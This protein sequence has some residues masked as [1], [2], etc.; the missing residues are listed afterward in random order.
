MNTAIER[1]DKRLTPICY[2]PCGDL[3]CYKDAHFLILGE[4]GIK[5]EVPIS[6][7]IKER[8]L[9]KN[10]IISRLLR[11]GVRAAVA[12]DDNTIIYLRNNILYELDINSNV[13]SKGY[14]CEQG[15]RPLNLVSVVGIRGFEDGIYFGGY[16]NNFDMKPVH[17]FKRCANDDWRIVYTFQN[18]VINHVHTIVPDVFRQCLWVFTGDFGKAAAIWKVTDNFKK[19]ECVAQ[20][21]QKYRSCVAFPTA[22]G[23]VYATDTPFTDNYIFLISEKGELKD[24]AHIDGSCIYGGMS[25]DLMFFSST[26]E[27]DGRNN[28]YKNL[29]FNYKR[30]AGIKNNYI[31]LYGGNPSIGFKEIYKLK[32]DLLPPIFQFSCFHFPAGYSATR[33][34]FFQPIATCKNDCSLMK[35]NMDL[36]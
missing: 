21:D 17:I 15:G 16:F 10:R 5:K 24:L 7:T 32:N 26:I 36:I 13:V 28:T 34:I 3:V 8:L 31:H 25:G 14:N 19:V 2:L 11:Y 1:I 4:K 27:P 18:G 20:N 9:G 6:V 12:V 29:F 33:T 23:L 30:G 22:G 35:I